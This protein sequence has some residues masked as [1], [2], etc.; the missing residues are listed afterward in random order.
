MELRLANIKE[1]IRHV[2]GSNVGGFDFSLKYAGDVP[3][4]TEQTTGAS[5]DGDGPAHHP[6]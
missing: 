2:F 4:E 1:H 6:R 5:R 3:A